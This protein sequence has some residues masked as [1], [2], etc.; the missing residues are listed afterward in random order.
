MGGRGFRITEKH[1]STKGKKLSL[2]IVERRVRRAI[3]KG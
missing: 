3:V 1:F 2:V